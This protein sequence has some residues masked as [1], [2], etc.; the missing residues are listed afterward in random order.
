MFEIVLYPLPGNIYCGDRS[1]S[2]W[3]EIKPLRNVV[4]LD[5]SKVFAGPF[6]SQQLSDLGAKVIKV[7][8]IDTGDDTRTWEPK[9]EC[10]DTEQNV[11]RDVRHL[12]LSDDRSFWWSS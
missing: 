1:R 6:C 10:Y 2:Y 4:I 3:E 9:R 5:L 11:R 12:C 7:E 8:P